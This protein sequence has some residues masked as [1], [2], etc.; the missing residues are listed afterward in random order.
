MLFG[1]MA[2]SRTLTVDSNLVCFSMCSVNPICR[3]H[4]F[5]E[6]KPT[7]NCELVLEHQISSLIQTPFWLIQDKMEKSS[8]RS[9]KVSGSEISQ[10]AFLAGFDL[11]L[12]LPTG[13]AFLRRVEEAMSIE[14]A[15]Y[16]A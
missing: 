13:K 2:F 12:F 3:G 7:N 9:Q 5:F 6:D 8:V 15:Q 14:N 4:M 10:K 1:Y 11:V 16:S